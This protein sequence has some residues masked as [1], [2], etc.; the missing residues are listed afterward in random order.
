MHQLLPHDLWLGHAREGAD[1]TPLFE[2]GIRALVELAAAE[3]P[4]RPPRELIYCRF[5]LIDGGGNDRKVLDLAVTTLANLLERGIPTLVA[6]GAGMSR[7]PAVAAPALSL[8]YQETPDDALKQVHEHTPC[9]VSPA[10]WDEIK[11]YLASL[12]L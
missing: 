12:R 5:P 10:L 9:D 7:S 2:A 11:Q 6:C 3:E 8:V 1:F 4:A